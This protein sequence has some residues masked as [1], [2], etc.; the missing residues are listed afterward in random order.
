MNSTLQ[1]IQS[2]NQLHPL[3]HSADNSLFDS[4]NTLPVI[5]T[6]PNYNP[7]DGGALSNALPSSAVNDVIYS[8]QQIKN[9]N[10]LQPVS[11]SP[12][13][14]L[15]NNPNALPLLYAT[16]YYVLYDDIGTLKYAFDYVNFTDLPAFL[17]QHNSIGQLTVSPSTSSG[18]YQLHAMGLE[19]NNTK[20]LSVNISNGGVIRTVQLA[21]KDSNEI[22]LNDFY[23]QCELSPGDQLQVS[24]P[25]APQTIHISN[26][27]ATT[28]VTVRWVLWEALL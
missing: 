5:Y 21:Q 26:Q 8:V 19:D 20:S 10:D 28:T 6:S 3:I 7:D 17:N 23:S 9:D 1:E 4:P 16:N 18:T 11:Q 24:A 22:G 13:Y 25:D 15:Y 12:G 2:D 27:T 14:N